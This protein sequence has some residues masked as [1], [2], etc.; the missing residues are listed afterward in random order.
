MLL[1]TFA[2]L[3]ISALPVLAQAGE[4]PA[5]KLR[6]AGQAR[7]GELT[8]M[9][10]LGSGV[11]RAVRIY[12]EPS[13]TFLAAFVNENVP[14]PVNQAWLEDVGFIR[15]AHQ[16]PVRSFPFAIGTRAHVQTAAAPA[17]DTKIKVWIFGSWPD[18]EGVMREQEIP[19]TVT[20]NLGNF[21]FTFSRDMRLRSAAAG[22]GKGTL[23]L[24][25]RVCCGSSTDCG[26]QACTEGCANSEY[27]C[28]KSSGGGCDWCSKN[29]VKCGLVCDV[30]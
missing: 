28:Y 7:G 25:E 15:S 17:G 19:V 2:V 1:R 23:F 18:E 5:V 10:E 12:S 26:G 24:L 29:E 16:V 21:D 22:L 27:C 3:A 20:T 9:T 30:C 8:L 6:L 4:L 14:E 13:G 11:T